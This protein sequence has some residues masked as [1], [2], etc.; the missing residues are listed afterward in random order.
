MKTYKDLEDF[1]KKK[2]V[3]SIQFIET[4]IV[5]PDISPIQL[6]VIVVDKDKNMTIID[7]Q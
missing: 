1:A 5:N 2:G 4:T 6:P 7:R 3:K